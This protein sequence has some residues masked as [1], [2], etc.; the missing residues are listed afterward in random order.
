MTSNQVTVI[1][2]V[3]PLTSFAIRFT[4]DLFL[5]KDVYWTVDAPPLS[6]AQ[7]SQP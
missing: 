6:Y 7:L 2:L 5:V 4:V 1:Q 3:S